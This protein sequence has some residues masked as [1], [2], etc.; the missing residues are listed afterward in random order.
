M[1]NNI[2][3]SPANLGD[4]NAFIDIHDCNIVRLLQK[5]KNVNGTLFIVLKTLIMTPLS[6]LQVL[7]TPYKISIPSLCDGL[8]FE[9]CSYANKTKS[10]SGKGGQREDCKPYTLTSHT[11][12]HSNQEAQRKAGGLRSLREALGGLDTRRNSDGR[13]QLSNR[14][15]TKG[16]G[17]AS[18]S[19]V[20]MTWGE[21]S[22]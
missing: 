14:V 15:V 19:G 21:E 16:Q 12:T 6:M 3:A 10:T 13:L 2:L 18:K 9:H 5:K 20:S 1:Q 8:K 11:I 7:Q 22:M 17:Q 4:W